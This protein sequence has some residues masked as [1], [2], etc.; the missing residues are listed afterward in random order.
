MTTQLHDAYSIPL[1]AIDVSD[2]QLYQ[3][4]AWYPYFEPLRREAPVHPC[5][6]SRCG[7]YWSVCKY[8]TSCR[9]R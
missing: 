7:S 9:S 6:E 2:P 3:N 1:E 8:K 4:D 5:R